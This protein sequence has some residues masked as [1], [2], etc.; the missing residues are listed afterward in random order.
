MFEGSIFFELPTVVGD[1]LIAR[2]TRGDAPDDLHFTV[3]ADFH[4]HPDLAAAAFATFCGEEYRDIVF[5]FPVSDVCKAAIGARTGA[6]VFSRGNAEPRKTGR[7]TG[8]NF[9]GGFDSL[10][11]YY[12]APAEQKRIAVTFGDGLSGKAIFFRRF[13]PM[14]FAR[15]IFDRKATRRTIGCSWARF[16]SFSPT[17]S[18]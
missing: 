11:A 8:L 9:S 5:D 2:V 7:N 10:A 12:L 1:K 16:P 4:F 15:R 3:P 6:R 14:L 13:R 18:T 17:I